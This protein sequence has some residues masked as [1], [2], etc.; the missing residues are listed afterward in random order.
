VPVTDLA[1]TGFAEH[2]SIRAGG[3]VSQ[4]IRTDDPIAAAE[5]ISECADVSIPCLVVGGGTN[6]IC[7][8]D[9][10][11]GSVVQLSNSGI[12]FERV[13]DSFRVDVA[14]GESWDDL[15]AA[16]VEAGLAALAPLSGIPGLVGA[17]P[18]QNV[19][20]YGT[21]IAQVLHSV[22]AWDRASRSFITLDASECELSYRSSVFKNEQD[23]YLITSVRFSLP[24]SSHDVI[25][26]EQ[27]ANSLGVTLGDDA[28]GVHIR[29]HVLDLRRAKAMVL[30][31]S[32][33]DTWSV[34]SFF[35][36]PIMSA[37][38]AQALPAECPRYPA[39]DQVKEQ[40]KVSAAWLLEAAGVSKGW[41]CTPGSAA[42]VSSRHVLAVTNS[43]GASTAAIIELAHEMRDRVS[44]AFEIELIPEPR[45]VNC[46]W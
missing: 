31:P 34:G 29:E 44:A 26:Y 27:L 16:T 12:D 5:Y 23:R 13:G 30:D 7:G 42:R 45:F 41:R 18:V 2:T 15:V 35:L 21:D 40:V 46:S 22:D 1:P 25:R 9:A 43:G 11:A 24:N 36:N 28:P 14:A 4:W 19:G 3:A 17:T 8:D 33:H 38:A 20:A 37:V 10:F 39:G 32:D 6:L